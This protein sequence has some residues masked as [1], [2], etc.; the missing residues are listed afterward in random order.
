MVCHSKALHKTSLYLV[1]EV[2]PMKGP[3]LAKGSGLMQLLCCY[4]LRGSAKP[5][6][7]LFSLATRCS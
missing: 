6:P 7:E 1:A 5:W 4:S 3:R 2:T